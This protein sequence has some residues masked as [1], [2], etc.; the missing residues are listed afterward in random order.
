MSE[1][2]ADSQQDADV[3]DLISEV[4][5]LLETSAPRKPA[6]RKHATS[7]RT[8]VVCPRCHTFY[9]RPRRRS[10]KLY[11]YDSLL[12]KVIALSVKIYA[13]YIRK[14]KEYICL[15]CGYTWVQ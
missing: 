5:P 1:R 15:T 13:L 14:S 12:L 3:D 6:K 10:Q 11:L 4:K 8:A 7:S 2:N 9:C